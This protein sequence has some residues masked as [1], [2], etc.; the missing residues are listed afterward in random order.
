MSGYQKLRDAFDSLDAAKRKDREAHQAVARATLVA[1]TNALGPGG[2]PPV[3]V[4]LAK[5]GAELKLEGAFREGVR[6][7]TV[8]LVVG[9]H[10]VDLPLTIRQTSDGFE[11]RLGEAHEESWRY[12]HW[13]A[14]LA[15]NAIEAAANAIRAEAAKIGSAKHAASTVLHVDR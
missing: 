11:V 1:L 2:A 13:H 5:D 6:T 14:T 8:R 12:E 9:E 7:A 3:L 4:D 15:A 10:R